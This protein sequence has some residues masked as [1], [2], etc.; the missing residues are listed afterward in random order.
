MPKIRQELPD[1]LRPYEFHG[2]DLV[3]KGK[4]ATADCPF[5]GKEGKFSVSV[6]T[7]QYKCWAGSCG[8]TGN[9]HVFLR[10][11]WD[12]SEK[13]TGSHDE[14][15]EHRGFLDA[16]SPLMWEIVRSATTGDWLVPGYS[17]DG[18]LRQLYRYVHG[19]DRWTLYP[20]P[21][22]GHQVHGVN[23]YD[24]ARPVVWLCE[25]PWDAVALWETLGKTKGEADGFSVTA[26]PD[27]SL[28]KECSVL[29][30][31][32]CNVFHESWLPL[33]AGK[34]VNLMFDS[35]HP[36]KNPKTGESLPPAGYAG[37]LRVAE[38]MASAREAPS[39]I[40]LLK[41]G[42]EGYDP[43]LKSGHDVR[44][45][46]Q[47]TVQERAERFADLLDRLE[48]YEVLDDQVDGGVREE[49]G[50]LATQRCTEYRVLVGAWRKALKWRQGMDDALSVMLAVAASTEQ[51]GDQLFL[52]VI[53]D[54]GSGKTRFCDGMLV[55]KSCYPLEHL[56]G[57]HSGWKGDDAQEYSLLSRINRKC[58]IT[59][60]GDVL[61]SSPKFGEIM[62]QQ[63]RIF[64][65]TSGASYKNM[66]KDQRF[67]GLRTPWIIAGTP[68]LLDSDQSR[69]GDR[70]L[71]VCFDHPDEDEKAAIVRHVGYNALRA[72]AQRSDGSAESHLDSTMA[73][74]YRLTGGYV[75]Y[76]RANVTE[77]VSQLVID[78]DALVE[79][80]GT[81]GEFTAFLR[82]R[83]SKI[84]DSEADAT[85]EMPT[86]LTSQFVRLACCL[87]VVLNRKGVD[88]E[89]LRRTKKVALDTARGQTLELARLMQDAGDDGAELR[90]LA[91]RTSRSEQDTRVTLR[92]LARIGAVEARQAQGT[93]FSKSPRW[94]LTRKMRTLWQE[95]MGDACSQINT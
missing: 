19:P 69:L 80:C 70:F 62:S 56:S 32:G 27:A 88:D 8:K 29:A 63:R 95:V 35:D 3:A 13:S 83:P 60:E 84:K 11:L 44:D 50:S 10:E 64:D 76:L 54:A 45:H 87:A 78:E 33:F 2:L 16:T 18:T 93:G 4:Q 6:E 77:L 72:V 55:S 58:L 24:P 53:G 43:L 82:A 67:T 5:C 47:G 17:P 61:I 23:L 52:R 74:A 40:N 1:T 92:F 57:F 94:R 20:T 51:T 39:E 34:V 79:F 49:N 9:A 68:A 42:P 90:A 85:K 71:Q 15:C 41:W 7:G 22:L 14:L 75:D 28:L 25:G 38:M 91:L 37:M 46:L 81:L 48:P 26:N 73:E 30:V 36:K 65:G 31:P 86:R 21:T 89:V 66:K 59:P 12:L